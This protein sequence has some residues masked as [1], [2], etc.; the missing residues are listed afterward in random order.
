MLRIA[1]EGFQGL[2]KVLKRLLFS[3]DYEDK[4]GLRWDHASCT[5][6]LIFLA[7]LTIMVNT[8]I[9]TPRHNLPLMQAATKLK[10]GL[11]I[12]TRA[13]QDAENLGY[14]EKRIRDLIRNLTIS[15]FDHVWLLKDEKNRLILDS[16]GN[17]IAMDVYS[18]WITAPN[19]AQCQIYLK[20]KLSGSSIAVT[21][22]QSF[23]QRRK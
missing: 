5:G 22:V 20:M 17:E 7:F 16:G 13:R 8:R 19:G 3:R 23:H 12:S 1:W 18:P 6:T 10:N 2:A 4:N 9:K 21:S 15:D 14:D 11:S